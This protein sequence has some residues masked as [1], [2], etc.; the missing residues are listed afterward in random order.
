MAE[1]VGFEP[2]HPV[3][4]TLATADA[5]SRDTEM[6]EGKL[7]ASRPLHKA[8]VKFLKLPGEGFMQILLVAYHLSFPGIREDCDSSLTELNELRLSAKVYRV[9]PLSPAKDVQISF[10]LRPVISCNQD[11]GRVVRSGKP[12]GY[13]WQ[14]HR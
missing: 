4:S 9:L 2:T 14:W 1:R 12:A 13:E 6:P 7:A 5:C 8:L 11:Y 3:L 10:K